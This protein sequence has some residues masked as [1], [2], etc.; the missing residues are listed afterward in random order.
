MTPAGGRCGFMIAVCDTSACSLRPK[1]HGDVSLSAILCADASLRSCNL[2]ILDYFQRSR[3]DGTHLG[4]FGSISTT[5][6]VCVV[7]S[8]GW[9]YGTSL[10]DTAP[11]SMIAVCGSIGPDTEPEPPQTAIMETVCGY[12]PST[13]PLPPKDLQHGQLRGSKRHRIMQQSSGTTTNLAL[14][15]YFYHQLRPG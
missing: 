6:V 15:E 10:Q 4:P 14:L 2:A 3:T 13:W 12:S 7:S 1:V 8:S 11:L 9:P 5:Q